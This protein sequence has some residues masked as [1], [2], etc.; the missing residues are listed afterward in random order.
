[1]S[2]EYLNNLVDES[3]AQR[4]QPFCNNTEKKYEQKPQPKIPKLPI[5]TLPWP[6]SV[7]NSKYDLVM[8]GTVA[9]QPKGILVLDVDETLL[10]FKQEKLIRL[11]RVK[12]LIRKAIDNDCIVVIATAREFEEKNEGPTFISHVV[13]RVGSI[14]IKHVY[15]TRNQTKK[16]ILDDLYAQYF[17]S[18]KNAKMKI[19]LADDQDR[20]LQPCAEAGYHTIKVNKNESVYLDD[21]ECFISGL[22]DKKV[23][24]FQQKGRDDIS[25][26][27]KKSDTTYLPPLPLKYDLKEVQQA[28]PAD[29]F[30]AGNSINLF[31]GKKLVYPDKTTGNSDELCLRKMD[32]PG[33]WWLHVV[34]HEINMLTNMK[35]SIGR[36]Y[37][38]ENGELQRFYS[39]INNG[40]P[41]MEYV[42]PADINM[43]RLTRPTLENFSLGLGDLLKN[44]KDIKAVQQPMFCKRSLRVS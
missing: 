2:N 17:S 26:F 8:R 10:D 28:L 11:V 30:E 29:V 21:I 42:M 4:A 33:R 22:A 23:V 13:D 44:F 39:N 5:E 7:N 20:F 16:S 24:K 37:E 34:S 1:M 15:F 38:F 32:R 18:D 9:V 31:S 6:H 40:H 12:Q 25:L 3:S 35:F 36:S 43:Q 19:A 41:I 14:C 27:F